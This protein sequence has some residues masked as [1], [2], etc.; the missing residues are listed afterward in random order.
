MSTLTSGVTS[1]IHGIAQWFT[2]QDIDD[3][4]ITHAL[5]KVLSRRSFI[6]GGFDPGKDQTENELDELERL[7]RQLAARYNMA[8][9]WG[10]DSVEVFGEVKARAFSERTPHVWDPREIENDFSS[11]AGACCEREFEGIGKASVL[12]KGV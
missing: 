2:S 1:V 4:H 10:I 5:P 3:F 9:A 7:E 11:G 6:K 12:G 8:H